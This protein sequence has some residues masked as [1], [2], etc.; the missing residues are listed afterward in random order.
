MGNRTMKRF[1]N[2]VLAALQKMGCPPPTGRAEG[3]S[4]RPALG[5]RSQVKAGFSI[6][7]KRVPN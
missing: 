6:I 5:V 2:R 1:L 7:L 3:L 4:P